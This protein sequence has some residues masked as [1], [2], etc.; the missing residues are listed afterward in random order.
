MDGARQFGLS[1][2][3]LALRTGLGDTEEFPRFIAYY[4]ERP[5][6]ESNR[7]RIYALLDAPSVAGAYRFD[8]DVGDT[9]TMDVDAALYPRVPLAHVGFAPSTSMFFYAKN[10]RRQA[11]D[12]RPEIHDS[13]G[14]QIRGGD[15]EWIWRPLLNPPA[16][17]I[18]TFAAERPRGFGL[19]QRERDFAQYQDDAVFYEKR[20]NLWVEPKGDWGRG[21][22]V[23]VE[24]PTADETLD[25]IVA[26]WRPADVPQP[27]RELLLAYKLYWC[28]DLP[29]AQGVAR[30]RA[31][32]TGVGGIVGQKRK[33]FSW[34]FV[35]D[36]AGG[37]LTLLGD[38][39]RVEPKIWAS[40]GRIEITSA[41]PIASTGMWRAMFDLVPDEG[42]APINLRLFLSTGGQALTETWL[43]QYTPPP[44][45]QRV[46]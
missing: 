24:I 19:M 9:L 21:A 18:N 27:G 4:L 39:A 11:I 36:F 42:V 44:S 34:R 15:G 25:N 23:L 33:Y 38:N 20:P 7:V 29:V 22:V 45:E 8:I 1:A 13:D 10:D 46:W 28:R 41:R 3:G 5:A 31:T 40:R 16:V 37:D 43:Y 32:R 26:F 6:R 14:L 17:Q 2:R 30:V 35:V 12:W